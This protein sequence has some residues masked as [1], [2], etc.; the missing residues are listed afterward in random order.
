M[1]ETVVNVIKKIKKEDINVDSI[2][3]SSDLIYDIGFDSLEMVDFLLDIENELDISIDLK[4]LDF[5]KMR[6]IQTFIDFISYK[7]KR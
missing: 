5:D 1:L 3:P 7:E 2:K 4:N 6:T